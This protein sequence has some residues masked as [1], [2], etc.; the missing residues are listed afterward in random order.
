MQKRQRRPG[1][2]ETFSVS[3]DRETKRLLKEA[4]ARDHGGN[5]SALITE[6]AKEAARRAAAGEFLRGMGV[7]RMTEGEA[8]AFEKEIARR[9]EKAVGDRSDAPHE[10]SLRVRYGSADWRRAR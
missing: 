4:A 8:D 2:T 10:R 5:V 3:V 6:L 7:P 1:A 9:A